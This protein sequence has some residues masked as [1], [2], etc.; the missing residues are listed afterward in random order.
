MGLTLALLIAAP[1]GAQD[2]PPAAPT[3]AADAAIPASALTES[4]VASVNDDV[5]TNYDIL[6]RMRLLV[7][8]AGI[9]L[10]RD[11]IPGTGGHALSS[12]IDEHPKSR[13]RAARRR[14]RRPRSSPPI[15]SS[16]T[17]SPTWRRTCT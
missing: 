8:T 3:P 9:Q 2:T 15:R 14:S 10:T 5:I 7:V 6:Q 16:T 12:L 17:S 4:V 1:V 13:S 11:D